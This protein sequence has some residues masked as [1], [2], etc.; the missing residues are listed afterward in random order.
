MIEDI[1]KASRGYNHPSG[2][3]IEAFSG[4]PFSSITP[5]D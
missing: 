2:D 4:N 5:M 3:F 1:K